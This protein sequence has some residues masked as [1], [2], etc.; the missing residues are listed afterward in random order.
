MFG[1]WLSLTGA[2]VRGIGKIGLPDPTHDS[3]GAGPGL[4][5]DILQRKLK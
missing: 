3:D 4:I 1:W 2:G 5:R